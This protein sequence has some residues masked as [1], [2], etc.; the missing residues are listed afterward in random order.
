MTLVFHAAAL[1]GPAQA[2]PFVHPGIVGVAA[3]LG[4]I[5]IV[6]HLINRRRYARMPWAA[7]SFLIAANRRSARRMRI[8]QWLLLS[9]RVLLILL[10]GLALARP[11]FPASQLLPLR[12]SRVHRIVL[13]DNSLS[14]NIRAGGSA[15]R[16]ETARRYAETLFASFPAQDAVSLI[17]LAAPA[18]AVVAEPAFDRRFVREQLL[19][20]E[21]TQRGTDIVGGVELTGRILESGRF[22]PG[23]RAVY[24]VTD[25]AAPQWRADEGESPTAAVT[26]V[27]KL[28][29]TSARPGVEVVLINVAAADADNTAITDLRMESGLA[30]VGVPTDITADVR[31]FGG[32]PPQGVDVQIRVNGQTVRREVISR[33]T[34]N[35]PTRIDFAIEFNAPG[36]YLVEARLAGREADALSDDDARFLS[37]EVRDSRPV[38]LVDGRPSPD[39]LIRQTGFLEKALAPRI[40]GDEPM[41]LSPVVIGETELMQEALDDYEFVALCNVSGLPE[42]TWLHLERFVENGGGL[43]VFAGDLVAADHYNRFGYKDGRGLLPAILADA[44]AAEEAPSVGDFHIRHGEFTHPITAEF[45]EHTEGGLFTARVNRYL[46]AKINPRGG[47]ALLTLSNGDPMLI[48]GSFGQ[49]RV[50]LCTTTAGLDWTNLPAKG[51]YVAL[52]HKCAAYLVREHGMHRNL[53]VGDGVREPL[54]AAQRGLPLRVI[55]EEGTVMEPALV[56]EGDRLVIRHGVVERAGPITV[57][58]GSVERVFAV[59]IDPVESD[60]ETVPPATLA[61]AVGDR[62]RVVSG[63][64]EEGD[65][66]IRPKTTELGPLLLSVVMLLLLLEMWLAMRFGSMR[67]GRRRAPRGVARVAEAA[68]G[69][70]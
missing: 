67:T 23:N 28:A 16:F 14:M 50:L 22:A 30:G 65:T 54:T 43:F 24:V 57:S 69:A 44:T 60:P 56:P 45:R 12:E 53:L 36:T 20:I 6:I 21:A 10:L 26:A 29:E 41:I 37:V 61:E 39:L 42:E 40:A 64:H 68:A 35:A 33:L 9:A 46:P 49:G 55:T 2:V 11:Y 70:N 32:S 62:A 27:R 4:L 7:M 3:V 13:L 1:G 5:P 8:E 15:S 48:S 66:P 25:M 52:M 58:I 51:D 34:P 59:N 18:T 63:V 31:H 47:D 38:L 19:S 17:T